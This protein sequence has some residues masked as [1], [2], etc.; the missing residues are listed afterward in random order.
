MIRHNAKPRDNWE[1]T[2]ESQGLIF[3]HTMGRQIVYW[4]ES[5]YY[6][7]TSAEV[8]EI[9]RVTYELQQ[10]YLAAAQVV[11]DKDRFDEFAIPQSFKKTIVQAWNDEPPALYGRFDLAR[12]EDGSLKLLE[13]NADTP[14][15]LVESA[16][17]QWYW[18]QDR[19]PKRDQFNSL[20]EKIIA[21]FKDV[22]PYLLG[23]LY[24]AHMDS[25]ED[26]INVTYLRDLAE[27]AGIKC[28]TILMKEVGWGSVERCFVA[29]DKT[30]IKSIFKLYPW[31]WMVREKFAS[32]LIETSGKT[33]WMEPIWKMLLSNKAMLKVLW[34]LNP[35]HPNLLEAHYEQGDMTAYVKKPKLSREG[36]NVTIVRYGVTQIATSGD[37]GQEGYVYQA[38]LPIK[39][40]NDKT[41]VIGSWLIDQDPAGMGIR[42]SDNLVTNNLSSFVPHLF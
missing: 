3:H 17:I 33:Q 2:V 11:I 34:E 9:E 7:F 1:K 24:F 8:D 30:I 27:Q 5:A 10:L 35:G 42:E 13:Y 25:V 23:K 38:Y 19:F 21:K 39:T 29:P 22:K 26:A 16:I 4:N 36:A 40:F 31:E 12:G 20:H 28:E 15:S 41:P 14:T 6:E 32:H 37:Y 18:L